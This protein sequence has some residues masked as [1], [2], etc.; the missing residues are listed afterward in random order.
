M[1]YKGDLF[2]E[3]RGDAIIGG[4]VSQTLVHVELDGEQ[5]KEVARYPMAKRI[6]DVEQGPD[7]AIWLLEDKVDGR[8]LKLTPKT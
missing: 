4:L 7:G 1:I 6:R 8:L 5:A 2:A 3:W